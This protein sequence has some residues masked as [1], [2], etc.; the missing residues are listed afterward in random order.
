ML[1]PQEQW[2]VMGVLDSLQSHK[3]SATMRH[4]LSLSLLTHTKCFTLCCVVAT[5]CMTGSLDHTTLRTVPQSLPQEA[6]IA[7]LVPPD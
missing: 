5:S 3:V 1:F 4:S 6:K 2:R 7:C